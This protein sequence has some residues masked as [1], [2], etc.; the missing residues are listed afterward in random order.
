LNIF[1]EL[2]ICNDEDFISVKEYLRLLFL[3]IPG[4]QNKSIKSI[5]ELRNETH[6]KNIR[7]YADDVAYSYMRRALKNIVRRQKGTPLNVIR[8]DYRMIWDK[9]A[10][11]ENKIKSKE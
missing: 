11:I 7:S 3:E 4:Y 6:N 10:E 1:D 9:W 8:I 5:Y 2:I